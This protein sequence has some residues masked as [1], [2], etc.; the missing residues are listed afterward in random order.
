MKTKQTVN[1]LEIVLQ[2]NMARNYKS[3][4]KRDKRFAVVYTRVSSQEQ[5]ESNSSLETQLKLCKD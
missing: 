5:E 3:T 2:N 4:V 1:S